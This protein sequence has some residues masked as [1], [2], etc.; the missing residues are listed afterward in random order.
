MRRV[1][2]WRYTP[3]DVFRAPKA[4]GDFPKKADNKIFVSLDKARSELR[5]AQSLSN[6]LKLGNDFVHVGSLRRIILDHIGDQR[7][8]EL[9][10][11]LGGVNVWS[12]LKRKEGQITNDFL[13]DN[14]CNTH[15]KECFPY[16]IAEIVD[17][18]RKRITG[19]QRHPKFWNGLVP[20]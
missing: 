16:H 11:Q 5:L 17:I 10:P 14:K 18:R 8:N 1:G 4:S 15:N 12:T 7:M 6:H 2:Y 9:Q 19:I 13:S 20:T 3:N